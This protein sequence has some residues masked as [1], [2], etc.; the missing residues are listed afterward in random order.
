[1]PQNR[2]IYLLDPKKLS[3]E[4]I[5]V[6]FAKTSR[7]PL[8]FDAIADEL[9]D[10]RSAD[11]HEKWVVGYGHSSVAEHAVL[12]IAV[13]NVSRLAIECLESNRLASY[14]EK[15]SR[16][17]V[18]D[19]DHFYIPEEFLNE[20][21]HSLFTQTCTELFNAYQLA[22]NTISDTLGRQLKRNEDESERGFQT[23]VRSTSADVCRYL[24]PACS[25]A[26]VG[27]SINA[28]ALEHAIIKMLSHPLREVQSIGEEIKRNALDHVPTLVKYANPSPYM[29]SLQEEANQTSVKP[30]AD[31]LAP[32]EWCSC[33]GCDQGGQ[34]RIL[35]ALVYRFSNLRMTDALD[36]VNL[37]DDEGKKALAKQF[38]A[39]KSAHDQPPREFEYGSATFDLVL[40]QGAYF[41]LKRHRM[42]TQTVQTFTPH[43]GFAMPK[44]IETNGLSDIFESMMHKASAAFEILANENPAAAAYVLPNAFNRRVM[45]DMN[46]RS[47]IHLIK[48]RCAENAHFAIR[49]PTLRIAE[50]LQQY[51]SLFNELLSPCTEETWQTVERD[52]FSETH[53]H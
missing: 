23:R 31:N 45:L 32:E 17:Q 44:L 33:I 16:Y 13:E 19:S 35:A 9:S 46:L 41:E 48:L 25:L 15:S 50:L 22:F 20:Q 8:A 49:R 29:I 38:I 26:N 6:T 53:A 7:S 1:M 47:A 10:A 28:R 51:F 37:L 18:W 42:M 11:F 40:D 4:T 36:K 12:H 3:P 27:I 34:E 30:A 39:M 24:L 2:R 14:T 5:A 21:L 43:L 52:F